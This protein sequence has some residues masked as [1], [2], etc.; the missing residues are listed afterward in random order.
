MTATALAEGGI[1]QMPETGKLRTVLAERAGP[2]D[3]PLGLR[4]S[5]TRQG[6]REKRLAVAGVGVIV[7]VSVGRLVGVRVGV[8]VGGLVWV[9]VGVH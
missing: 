3:G 5:A 4:V 6:A 9:G 8:L 1:P 2:P 7:G